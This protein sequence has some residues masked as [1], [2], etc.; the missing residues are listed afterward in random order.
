MIGK[1]LKYV[2]FLL[3]IVIC[4][5]TMAYN[6]REPLSD[7]DVTFDVNVKSKIPTTTEKV[8]TQ[9]YTCDFKINSPTCEQYPFMVDEGWF[10]DQHFGG[11]APSTQ[12]MCS[13]RRASWANS[14]GL[15]TDEIDM[16]Y[17]QLYSY[18][19]CYND[20]G[21]R[22]LEY[23]NG[24]SPSNSKEYCAKECANKGY[25]YFGIQ[26]TQQCFCG[27][28]YGKYGTSENCNMPCSGNNSET[29]GGSW[30]NSV[31]KISTTTTSAN[32]DAYTTTLKDFSL[33][34]TDGN[35]VIDSPFTNSNVNSTN[36]P[37]NQS[38]N[39]SISDIED[40]TIP[41]AGLSVGSDDLELDTATVDVSTMNPDCLINGPTS[42]T[43][44]NQTIVNETNKD[45]K[46]NS[47]YVQVNPSCLSDGL[48]SSAVQ[49]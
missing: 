15:S 4:I 20:S 22:D 42:A 32:T 45:L 43:L 7:A 27:S 28:S 37:N 41:N 17:Q 3:F 24:A 49:Y 6:A 13:A 40:K 10:Q 29:C 34:D 5:S 12:D 8:D 47:N 44:T 14:C 18:I 31:Y 1:K 36:N 33:Y 16:D 21:V 26:D 38:F 30:V 39:I 2:C 35:T 48:S 23:Y 9:L 19:G 25:E 11:P 46:F